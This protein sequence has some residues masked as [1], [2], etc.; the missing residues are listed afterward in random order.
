MMMTICRGIGSLAYRRVILI[1]QDYSPTVGG[2][3][4]IPIALVAQ[5]VEYVTNPKFLISVDSS[6]MVV[7]TLIKLTDGK[8]K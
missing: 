1:V 3:I 2:G 8:T 7:E 6:H 4:N 5:F